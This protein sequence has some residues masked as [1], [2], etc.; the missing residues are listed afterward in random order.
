MNENNM[1]NDIYPPRMNSN[2]LALSAVAQ[3][4]R[5]KGGILQGIAMKRVIIALTASALLPV[6]ANAQ[7][8]NEALALAYAT[9]PIIGAERAQYRSTREGIAQARARGLPQISASASYSKADG[10]QTINNAA[11]GAAGITDRSFDLETKSV[12]IQG[13]QTIFAGLRNVNAIRQAK[14]RANAGDAQLSAVEQDILLRAAEAYFAVIRDMVVFQATENNVQV[15]LKQYEE[16]AFR[17]EIGEVTRTDVAQTNARLAQSRAQMTTA[18]ARL[19]ISRAA[20]GEFIGQMPATLEQ[21]PA[22]PETPASLEE[23]RAIA[24]EVSPTIIQAMMREE[25]SRRGVSIAKGAFAPSV[26][27]TAGYQYAEEPSTFITND[28]QFAYGVRLSAPIFLGGLNISRV[29][30]ARAAN[31]ADRRRIVAAERR[32]EVAVTTA[33]R[34]LGAARA[35]IVS[36][37]TSVAANELALAGVR[38]ESEIGVRTTLDVLDAEQEYLDAQVSLA[39]AKRDARA[40]TFQLLAA[41]GILTPGD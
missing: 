31:T 35:N 6:S 1:S 12:Q 21:D 13:E 18:R 24:N 15:L 23:A 5:S 2:M 20:F 16:A 14:A 30:E 3:K 7:T 37:E 27:L 10:T 17:F 28:D 34:Q 19:A 29:R 41:M 40:A 11:L 22:L 38:R 32:I 4:K 8:L 39:N 9:N 25:A 26:A 36:A 33:W